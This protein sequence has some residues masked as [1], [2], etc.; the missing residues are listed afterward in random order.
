M[1]QPQPKREPGVGAPFVDSPNAVYPPMG[2][3]VDTTVRPM[4]PSLL[5]LLKRQ[6]PSTEQP[7][8][9]TDQPGTSG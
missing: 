5:R 4:R 7:P 9:P 2:G 8:P 1:P 6:P 3:E